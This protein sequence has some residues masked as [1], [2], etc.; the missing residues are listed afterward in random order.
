MLVICIR[1]SLPQ[2][3]LALSGH[4]EE[5][6]E[7]EVE[8]PR[9]LVVG[10][11]LVE[12]GAHIEAGRTVMACHIAAEGR[13]VAAVAGMYEVATEAI[14]VG[15]ELIGL[16]EDYGYLARGQPHS[17]RGQDQ[18]SSD[19]VPRFTLYNI[20]ILSKLGFAIYE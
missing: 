20:I 5:L 7:E 6:V 18:N 16:M 8:E 3:F 9:S 14:V 1:D 10:R 12:E 2:N 19:M 15:R 13:K 11:T 4:L 17:L